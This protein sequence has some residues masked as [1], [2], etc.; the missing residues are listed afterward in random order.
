VLPEV[1]TEVNAK[2]AAFWD[3]TT[4]NVKET[5]PAAST[6]NSWQYCA[7]TN[8]TY[9]DED[10]AGSLMMMQEATSSEALVHFYQ[11]TRRDIPEDMTL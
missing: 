5:D 9:P 10:N 1:L 2:T 3:M 4:C 6:M 11:T 7:S 8:V